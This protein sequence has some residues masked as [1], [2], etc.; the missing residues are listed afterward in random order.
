MGRRA[1][2]TAVPAR[3]LDLEADLGAAERELAHA[4]AELEALRTRAAGTGRGDG[5]AAPG[6]GR[7]PG[8][9]RDGPPPPGRGRAPSGRGIRRRPRRAND[10]RASLEAELAGARE[11]AFRGRRGGSAGRPPAAN[12]PA[13]VRARP[14]PSTPPPTSGPSRRARRPRPCARSSTA[15]R[16]GWRTRRRAASRGRPGE[17]A[18]AGSTR[19]S[20]S[21]RRCEPL[22]RPPSPRRHV[23]TSSRPTAVPTLASERGSLAGHG[24]RGRSDRTRGRTRSTLSRGDRRGRWRDPRRGGPTRHD[25]RGP[26]APRCAPPG[27]PTW[28]PA[29]PSRLR[30]RRVGSR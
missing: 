4:V 25:R 14:R 24:T 5:S 6:D 17:P 23:P 21:I 30:C 2:A 20:T 19:I 27:C 9:S 1:L 13:S 26:T 22:R 28:L 8:G 12:V 18:V 11:V 7:A 15:S 3:D 10:E 29:S 16:R